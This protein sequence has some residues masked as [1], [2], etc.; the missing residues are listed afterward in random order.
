[1]VFMVCRRLEAFLITGFCGKGCIQ[2]VRSLQWIYKS[3]L[4][5]GDSMTEGS[6]ERGD[7]SGSCK[8]RF[9]I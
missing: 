8:I 9:W 4:H 5:E 2:A 1:M 6:I 3:S 7:M